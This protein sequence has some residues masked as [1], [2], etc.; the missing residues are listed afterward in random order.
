MEEYFDWD[1]YVTENDPH[2]DLWIP[3]SL[4]IIIDED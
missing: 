1:D 3:F 2:E 4:G